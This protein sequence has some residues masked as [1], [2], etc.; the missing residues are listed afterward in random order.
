MHAPAIQLA[1]GDARNATTSA[2]SSGVPNRPNG[3]S[4][5]DHV[6][7]RRRGR[8]SAGDPSRR[9]ETGSSPARR[10]F[11]RMLCARVVARER[12]R[13]RDHA[14]LRDV[15]AG[16]AAGL[17]AP[18]RRDHRDRAAAARDQVRRRALRDA[19]RGPQVHVERLREVGV[20][21]RRARRARTTCRRSRRRRRCR[22]ARCDAA[23]D[24]ARSRRRRS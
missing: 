7:D 24:G 15:V 14:G 2:T 13:E 9:R 18:D 22:R 12:L 23:V 6:G 16:R 19:R 11:T 5:C 1:R 4:R 3:S 8:P 17:A 21:H 10:E 20:V